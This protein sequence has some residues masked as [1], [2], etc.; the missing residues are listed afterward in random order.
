M[1]MACESKFISHCKAM[2]DIARKKY[3]TFLLKETQ[4]RKRKLNESA[5]KEA[6]AAMAAEREARIRE[7]QKHGILILKDSKMMN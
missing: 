1:Q 6:S 3:A 7:K 2:P 4:K 5:D